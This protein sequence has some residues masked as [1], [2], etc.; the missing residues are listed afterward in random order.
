MLAMQQSIQQGVIN[1]LA[2]HR[3]GQMA[4][5]EVTVVGSNVILSGS[6]PSRVAHQTVIRDVWCVPSVSAIVDKLALGNSVVNDRGDETTDMPATQPT[7]YGDGKPE[8]SIHTRVI[9]SLEQS[10][11]LDLDP[12]AVEV[13][14]EGGTVVLEGIVPSRAAVRAALSAAGQTAGVGKLRNRLILAP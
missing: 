13:V 2:T 1:K 3:C 11:C 8:E 7:N 5:I 6:V 14:V 4:N 10:D 12:A 9:R